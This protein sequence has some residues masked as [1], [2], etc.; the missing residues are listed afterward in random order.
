[1]GW[2]RGEEG[3]RA[4]KVTWG[5]RTVVGREAEKMRG[6]E[7]VGVEPDMEWQAEAVAEVL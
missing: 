4:G 5:C 1:M 6:V 7:E 3:E 2:E